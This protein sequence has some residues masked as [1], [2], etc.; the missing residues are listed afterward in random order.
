[1]GVRTERRRGKPRMVID[2]SYI[3]A[4]TG[5]KGRY[6]KDA[7]VQ[8]KG[9]A[10]AEER[11]LLAQL[12]R[13]GFLPDRHGPGVVQGDATPEKAEPKATTFNDALKAF[14][15]GKAVVELKATTLRGYEETFK[16]YLVPRFGPGAL[17]A[18]DHAAV[19]ELD[20]E[21]V[22]A[23]LQ[24]STR[25]NVQIA[26]RSV[27]KAAVKA[28]A[29]P[30]MPALPELPR[31]GGKVFRPPSS[32]EVNRV[33]EATTQAARLALLL[34]SEAGLRAGEIRGLR[35]LDV[36][37]AEGTLCVRQTVYRGKVDT[38]K[39]GHERE[40]PLSPRLA[41]ALRHEKTWARP[42][43]GDHVSL[44][45][46]GTVWGESSLYHAMR[47]ALDKA[48]LPPGRVHDLRH[49]FVTRCFRAG[50]D[51]PTVQA[52][53]GHSHLSVTQRYAHTGADAKRELVRRLGNVEA[54][55]PEAG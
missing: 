10:Q 9:W 41:D 49:Y 3:D 11:R 37:L 8:T 33:L 15:A 19:T 23:G 38:P 29:L 13:D 16:A 32:G 44:S 24:P 25:R 42:E 48:G 35:W 7:Q 30:R 14:R 40:V 55:A 26:L 31:V 27:L 34:A 6:R 22:K 50:G 18:I 5:E 36:D 53:A 12:G 46:R 43:P 52:L 47:S 2:I 45:S 54:T 28:G 21:L 1:M 20:A 51:A 4:R 39:S 17:A